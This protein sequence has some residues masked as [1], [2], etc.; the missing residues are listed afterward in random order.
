[1][2]LLQGLSQTGLHTFYLQQDRA[3]QAIECCTQQKRTLTFHSIVLEALILLVSPLS[4]LEA[5]VNKR[6]KES[7][8]TIYKQSKAP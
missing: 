4:L 2:A 6:I 1:M 8:V 3:K 5:E 7:V